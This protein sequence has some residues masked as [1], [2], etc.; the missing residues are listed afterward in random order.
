MLTS[1]ALRGKKR[2]MKLPLAGSYD[3]M[4]AKVTIL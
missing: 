4:R 2:I 3:L 1:L